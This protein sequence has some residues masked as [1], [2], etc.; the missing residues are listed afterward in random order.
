METMVISIFSMMTLLIF[1]SAKPLPL[2]VSSFQRLYLNY[3]ARLRAV[4]GK[5]TNPSQEATL[6][7]WHHGHPKDNCELKDADAWYRHLGWR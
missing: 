1:A 7:E 6:A 5:L 2:E 3:C 4:F